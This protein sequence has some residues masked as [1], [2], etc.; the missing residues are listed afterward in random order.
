MMTTALLIFLGLS[1]C[2]SLFIIGGLALSARRPAPEC[3]L[4]S[5]TD[6]TITAAA[7][8]LGVRPAASFVRAF[9]H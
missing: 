7:S 6:A 4:E 1:A 5:V 8:D 3:D 9:S 2:M